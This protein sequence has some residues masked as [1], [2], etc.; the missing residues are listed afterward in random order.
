MVY[1]VPNAVRMQNSLIHGYNKCGPWVLPVIRIIY[2]RHVVDHATVPIGSYFSV[3]S[4]PILDGYNDNSS[5]TLIFFDLGN[6]ADNRII[7]HTTDT[8]AGL[9]SA[10]SQLDVLGA[11]AEFP[12]NAGGPTCRPEV[13][14]PDEELGAPMLHLEGMWHPC[15]VPGRG[16]AIVP[17]NLMLGYVEGPALLKPYIRLTNKIL[18]ASCS[19]QMEIICSDLR[20]NKQ[21]YDQDML[22]QV[23][24]KW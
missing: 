21:Y 1:A 23:S 7:A 8:I 22:C 19:S 12:V 10:L 5:I 6:I 20:W 11:L 4:M 17:N 2:C 18:T 15:A 16:G 14:P 3:C 9:Q 13:L 24:R